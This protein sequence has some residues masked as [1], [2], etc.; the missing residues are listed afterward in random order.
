MSLALWVSSGACGSGGEG[1]PAMSTARL[2]S[3][4]AQQRGREIFLAHCALCHGEEADGRGV[5]RAGLTG[6]PASFRSAA[7]RERA[8]PDRLLRVLEHGVPGTSMPAWPSL[9]DDDK[10]DVIAYILS[11]AEKGGA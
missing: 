1:A 8:D 11:V 10:R 3:A 4:A 5:R 9:S 7:W 6:K 2:E